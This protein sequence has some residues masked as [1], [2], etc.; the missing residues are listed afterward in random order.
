MAPTGGPG[1]SASHAPAH[2]SVTQT[3]GPTLSSTPHA[4]RALETFGAAALL[5]CNA[6]PTRQLGHL[7]RNRIRSRRARRSRICS[8]SLDRGA[9]MLRTASAVLF[10]PSTAVPLATLQG[11]RERK[12]LPPNN[13]IAAAVE[14]PVV[15]PSAPR[16]ESVP[17]TRPRG[18]ST[19]A[20]RAGLSSATPRIR[21]WRSPL[22]LRRGRGSLHHHQG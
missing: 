16:V 6:G 18:R 19:I 4:T 12:S 22:S 1:P 14:S 10:M 2:L 9:Y 7:L 8:Q 3:C 17:F 20:S 11:N 21:R 13:S 15:P 5:H